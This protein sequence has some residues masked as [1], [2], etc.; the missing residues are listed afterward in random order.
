MDA[1]IGKWIGFFFGMKTYKQWLEYNCIVACDG[2]GHQWIK[3]YVH[4]RSIHGSEIVFESPVTG[5]Q[6]DRNRTGL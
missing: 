3:F 6:K 4:S 5:L 2:V 1:V